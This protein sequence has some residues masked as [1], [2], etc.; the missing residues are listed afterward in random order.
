MAELV[1]RD[2]P[3]DVVAEIRR[4]AAKRGVSP[5]EEAGVLLSNAIF[6]WKAKAG[7]KPGDEGY[8]PL[9]HLWKLGEIAPDFEF[10]YDRN[11]EKLR[12]VDLE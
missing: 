8:T 2:V 11:Q 4:L 7:L 5:E 3:D 1:A 6:T 10:E 9:H 12:P